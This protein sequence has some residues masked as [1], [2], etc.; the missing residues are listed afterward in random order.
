MDLSNYLKC[1][2]SAHSLSFFAISIGV[3]VK[4]KRIYGLAIPLILVL[5]TLGAVPVSSTVQSSGVGIDPEYAQKILKMANDA[6]TR[7]IAL[8]TSITSNSTLMGNATINATIQ[9]NTNLLNVTRNQLQEARNKFLSGDYN[10]T[11]NLALSSMEGFRNIYRDLVQV[12]EEQEEGL[13]GQGLLVA[14]NCALERLGK[15][16]DTISTLTTNVQNAGGL[17]DQAKDL[18]NTTEVAILLQQG[19]VSEV[20]HRLAEANK[21]MSQASL[22]LKIRA[23]EKIEA[24]I[25]QYLQKLEQTRARIME[26]LNTTGINATELFT[27]FGFANMGEFKQAMNALNQM[28]KEHM[29]AGQLGK[30]MGILNFAAN[31]TQHLNHQ[32]QKRALTPLPSPPQG[33]PSLNLAAQISSIGSAILLE[34]SIENTGNATIVFPNSVYGATLEKNVDGNWSL[35]Y[36][37]ISAH[38][39]VSLKPGESTKI[40]ILVSGSQ[41]SLKAGHGNMRGIKILPVSFPSGTYRVTVHG[42]IEG[43][44]QPVS[45]ST[46][47]TIQ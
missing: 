32:L 26:R 37:P 2:V 30:A 33:E 17:I 36:T 29:G 13:K 46:E 45:Q 31:L 44:Y 43:T 5:A 9:N 25:D 41:E 19:N 27:Q 39:L 47:F 24:R 34:V 3:V 7:I 28:V 11:V 4:M 6:E 14:I 42:W 10:A 23:Q 16:S 38:V 15:M 21:L 35:F 20:A 22:M 40:N 8:W 12:L 18:L 1:G